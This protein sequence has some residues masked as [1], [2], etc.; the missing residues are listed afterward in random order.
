M[1]ETS[2]IVQPIVPSPQPTLREFGDAVT[3][4]RMI[5][6]NVASAFGERYPV[7]NE[8]YTLKLDGLKYRAPKDYTPAEQKKAIMRGRTL[9]W[10]LTG[11]WRLV[12]NVTQKTVD[13]T[14]PQLVVQVPYLTDRG[15]FIFNGNEY[16]LASQMRLR[17]GVYSRVKEN[18]LIEAHFNVAG[19]T[20]PS[21]RV[22][23]EP[24]TG[25]FRLQVGQA[26][27]K[28][29]PVLRAM[30]FA[31]KDL[32][33]AW[34]KELLH[35]NV[36]A[37]DPRAVQRAY[38][39]LVTSRMEKAAQQKHSKLAVNYVQM[40]T[41]QQCGQCKWFE[42]LNS[43][44]RVQGFIAPQG[45]C[46]L[47]NTPGLGKFAAA[48]DEQNRHRVKFLGTLVLDDSKKGREWG[49]LK[50]HKGLPEAAY[51]ALRDQGIDCEPKFD[52]PHIS[53]LRSHEIAALKQKYGNKWRKAAGE[54]RV[55]PFSLQ[56]AMVD[57]TPEGWTDMDRVWFL[58]AKS[59][60]LRAYRKS[61]G[62]DELPRGDASGDEF[63]FHITVAV[64]PKA[65][66]KRGES[67]LDNL[68]NGQDQKV[69]AAFRSLRLMIKAAW[70]SRVVGTFEKRAGR[71]PKNKPEHEAKC[72]HCGNCCSIKLAVD[73]VVCDTGVYCP[74]LDKQS[75][76]CS[77]YEER[78]DVSPICHPI[79]ALFKIGM[80]PA[81][82][83]YVGDYE[84]YTQ[85]FVKVPVT[86]EVKKL[87]QELVD[88]L[89]KRAGRA[90]RA[91]TLPF[92]LE[93]KRAGVV[94]VGIPKDTMLSK[95]ATAIDLSDPAEE[96][97]AEPAELIERQQEAVQSVEDNPAT[98]RTVLKTELGTVLPKKK[99]PRLSGREREL[100]DI[101]P[102]APANVVKTALAALVGRYD[103]YFS[104]QAD[105]QGSQL[106]AVFDRMELDEETTE[107]TLGKRVKQ[108]SPGLIVDVTK[109]LIAI[110]RREEQTDDR[111][112]L[113]F[114]RV[115]GP[116][117]LFA[118][119]ISRDAGGLG[120]RLLWRSTLKGGV[121]HIP[122]GA[123]S[124]QMRLLLLK[125]GLASSLEEVNPLEV[126]DQQLRVTRMGEGGMS[127]QDAVPDEARSVQPS[128][129]GIID[130][131]RSPESATIGVDS[132]V[133]HKT[134]K[135]SDGKFYADMLDVKTG[136]SKPVSVQ[137]LAASVVAFPGEMARRGSKVRA[138]VGSRDLKYVDRRD[139]DYELPHTSHMFAGTSNLVPAVS[140]V[141]GQRLMMG[142]KAPIQ[143]LPLR[144]P[145]APLVQSAYD[146]GKG[147]FED[148]YGTR[149]GA[150]RAQDAGYIEEVA[151]DHIK[152]R[153][154]GG[155]IVKH[156][157]FDN[158]PFNRKSVSGD[159]TIYIKRH[160]DSLWVGPI[161]EYAWRDGDK[162]LTIDPD[163]RRSAWL[164]VTTFIAH[165]N[166]K[167]LL[168]VTMR[169]GRA[170]TITEDH[171][172][173]VM[174]DDGALTP[175]YPDQCVVGKTRLPIAAASVLPQ[176]TELTIDEATLAGLYLAE[177]HIPPSQP[178]LV[179]I[180]VAPDRRAAQ[181]VELFKRLGAKPYRNG[182]HVCVSDARLAKL[183]KRHFGH[184]SHGKFIAPE[185]ITSAAPVREAIVAGYFAGDGC[186]HVDTNGAIQLC[187][188]SVSKRLRD[189]MALLLST[190]GVF[191]TFFER[192][193]DELDDA[194]R[195]AYGLRVTSAHVG[196]LG[197]WMFYDDR[198]ERL[199]ELL[200]ERAPR[201]SPY[202]VIPVPRGARGQL[203]DEFRAGGAEIPHF[204]YKTACHGHVAKHRAHGALG[205]F[206]DWSRSDVLWAIIDSIEPAPHEER[207]YDLSVERAEAFAINGGV[208]VHNTYLH[209]TPAVKVGDRVAK[210]TLLAKSNYTDNAGS[211]AVGKNFR[212][213]YMAYK[214]ANADDAVVISESA[215]HRLS[216]EHMYTTKFKPDDNQEADRRAYISL[217]PGRF[218]KKQLATIDDA[219]IVKPGTVLN[220]GDPMVLA[221]DKRK[222]RGRGVLRGRKALYADV[223]ETWD[224]TSPGVVTDV[225]RMKGG[226]KIL[227]K[228]Y[229][230]M[231]VG[232]K[233][234]GRYGNK[235]V[236]S[237]IVPDDQMPHDKDG[238]PVE[239][240]LTPL[241]LV[242]RVN[243]SQL[244]EAAL[245]KVAKKT[246]KP[247]KLPG[248][249]DGSYIDF[250]KGEL[251]KHGLEDTEDLIDP[252]TG[253]KVPNVFTG[254]SYML[255]LH[256]MAEPKAKGRDVGAYTAEGIPAGGGEGGSKRI[257][258]GELSALVSHGSTALIRD[259]KVVRGQRNDDYWRA[260]R[261]GYP[262]PSPK[263][264][265]VYD[266]F[267][268][269]LQGAGINL[270]K[271]GDV[272]HL[273]ALTDR[274]VD[275]LSAGPVTKPETVTGDT[276]DPVEGGL[277]D[278]GK[279]GGHGG[280]RWAHVTL[281]EPMP[282][283]VMEE[284]IRR[285][286]G[287][288]QKELHD[289]IAG[290]KEL[291]A[292]TG[293]H[294][295]KAALGRINVNEEIVRLERSV[296]EDTGSKRDLSV[297]KLG[298]LRTL[299]HMGVKPEEL[300]LSKVPV[301]PPNFR[302]ITAISG[303]LPLTSDAN[304]LYLDLIRA[305]RDFKELKKE[306]GKEN[307]GDERLQVYKAFK[308]VTGL[309]DPVA[310][311]SREVSARGLLK[312]VFGAGSPK[313][314][315]YQRRLLGAAVDTAGRGVITPNPSLNMDQVGLPEAKAWVV[316]RPFIV[317][318]LVRR[319]MRAMAAAEHISNKSEVARKALLEEMDKR[320][321]V[322]TR[323]PVLHRYGIMSAWPVLTKGSTLQ[324]PPIV[325][326]G[327]NADFDGDQQRGSVIVAIESI[328]RE[329]VDA[330]MRMFNLED[331]RMASYSRCA[332]PALDGAHELFVVDLQ[333]FPHGERLAAKDGEHGR[334][335]LHAVPPG[336]KVLAY[337]EC[338]ARMVWA[339]VSHWSKHYDREVEIVNL[340]G[341]YQI[342]TDDDP[343]GVYGV[344][345]GELAPR[346]CR[347]S[348]AVERRMLVP[349][350]RRLLSV[351]PSDPIMMIDGI[352]Q[353]N[354]RSGS[355]GKAA[356]PMVGRV[357]LDVDTGY[358]IGATYGDGWTGA[359]RGGQRMVPLAGVS[360]TVRSRWEAA[361]PA[362]YGAED[363]PG[364][365]ELPSVSKIVGT[366]SYGAS[367]RV[368]LNSTTLASWLAPLIGHGAD[369][370]HL[371]SFFM[372]T[373]REFREGLFAG[374]MDTAGS[375]SVSR[376]KRCP[377]LM[378]NFSS[379]SLRLICE[380][381]L[382]AAT[383]GIS[384][385][386]TA[387]STSVGRP[388]WM[389]NFSN[390]D[391]QQWGGRH[392]VHVDKLAKL[393]SVPPIAASTPA[394][395]RC[396]IVPVPV[397]L[398]DE[399][400]KKLGAPRDS[401]RER[402]SLYAALHAASKRGAISRSS[403]AR[404]VER[405]G[406]ET[407]EQY[408]D[409]AAWLRIVDCGDVTWHAV[410]S[411]E[412]TH[413]RETGYDLTVPG[414]ET[415]M[416]TEGVVLSN[417]MN[418]HVPVSDDAVKDAVNKMLPS[419]NVRAVADFDVHYY[420]RQEFL[421][422]LNLASTAR[423]RNARTFVTK[424]DALAAYRRGELGVGDQVQIM[425]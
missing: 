211:V 393:A 425:R 43:C 157:L 235:G 7:S 94:A 22:H 328:D 226:W 186:L 204:V 381:R 276:L 300:M 294:A 383:L 423:T 50:V 35:A 75:K 417:T 335:D 232:D 387:S 210:G 285:L 214:G 327:F 240:I 345:A 271:K 265:V 114:Q 149:V 65:K 203:Y 92:D 368:Q 324:I 175:A 159:T 314:G 172:L 218:D 133:T 369:N 160:D 279:T 118:E 120:R 371:P 339:D 311:K 258:S 89:I 182:G 374:L 191:T 221:V 53:V 176:G 415:F 129:F 326:S 194:R 2:E 67:V 416:T 39:K 9:G 278:V 29:Y 124:P 143:A 299:K 96:L 404:I 418:F 296:R 217:F 19:G 142:A 189:D 155:N 166:D 388:C 121:Q 332:L 225:D 392:M 81:S 280:G 54:G 310:V 150:I 400:R 109:K 411:V 264:P 113:A 346:R 162:A 40:G 21:F 260:L 104:K 76:L 174:G 18:G 195:R 152:V 139:V 241:G 42:G 59:P 338:A 343:R 208:V 362:F 347:P 38:S 181:I 397:A 63:Q 103:L 128:H 123:L 187:A 230:P 322:I 165:D 115:L 171:S 421:L 168:R 319:G 325:A 23:M 307:V 91:E 17:P 6:D 72:H 360:D 8:R 196:R 64:K 331:N 201:S 97:R 375:I 52:N 106:R 390:Y 382:L 45:W 27:L 51:A 297:K 252:V 206:G 198:E 389:L 231:Q 290:K 184:L 47:W 37:S 317:R 357:M 56:N 263:V 68:F 213:A 330:I 409:G 88:V 269:H 185:I 193:N 309:G 105:E 233:L 358:F 177:G 372:N 255:K 209:N 321:V 273:F 126:F 69:K 268:A 99:K 136:Q 219:G 108:V 412:A 137:E 304:Y 11:R 79:D 5:F 25:V 16:T 350:M 197:R 342:V 12:D 83:G 305:N 396:D 395:A 229:S 239:V 359:A 384:G 10:N 291:N 247:Y 407:V 14:K 288:T 316:Y 262:P 242:S 78:F 156:P 340:A 41:L 117:D 220:Q 98:D 370:K 80:A 74:F 140:G 151:K 244:A 164:P 13:E 406:R 320:P 243:P 298:Y 1:A 341:G 373:R 308:A 348:E 292:G 3:T 153:Y 190:L 250:T 270:R 73:N 403:A 386:I 188:H 405:L 351:E 385:R 334:I 254:Y 111:D 20:G 391:I 333:D 183:L 287:L 318:N 122:P 102:E 367:C 379:N 4:R 116:E 323:A 378:A 130:P 363:D 349:R 31:D 337:D 259:A 355:R 353:P 356:H 169:S 336:V 312:Q 228:A 145:E 61:L 272:T 253:R 302:P 135:G 15:T 380:V 202:E 376:G 112:A 24:E 281:D 158:F 180:A 84:N 119:R 146:G 248:F 131:V 315:M 66:K 303:S 46:V 364:A 207:V 62:L 238:N 246:G 71:T 161:A 394:R 200:A 49:Y 245:G 100:L 34:G 212:V 57:L 205:A 154:A 36:A 163:T 199:R 354:A 249:M 223:A 284:P 107:Q 90:G 227:A 266:K 167:R 301:I 275:G 237:Q 26:N 399:L 216:S 344:P 295:I 377:Q 147:S 267:L 148:V 125:S 82:C 420:P 402:K 44:R 365:S 224:H 132:R 414:Y 419:R 127:S 274:D 48:T 401:G 256:H 101:A 424:A 93:D 55:F 87:A 261:L 192:A 179:N 352:Q 28:L 215:A 408:D 110:N 144:D 313:Y 251:Q 329:Y 234:T 33:A 286:L 77:V 70:L 60:E 277:F 138:M 95:L 422:G 283:P 32:L 178:N 398:A 293:T 173:M 282:N 366:K 85:G 361:L 86:G 413:I 134:Y 58:E 306:L 289:V 30:G 170:F 222:P 257:G 141:K 410:E 236:V